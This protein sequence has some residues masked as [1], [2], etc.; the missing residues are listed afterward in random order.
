MKRIKTGELYRNLSA[1]L[2]RKG[3]EFKDGS[4]TER[5]KQSC[6]VLTDAVNVSQKA[7]ERAKTGV[8]TIRLPVWPGRISCSILI[9]LPVRT[10]NRKRS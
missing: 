4:Y 5:I 9:S 2:G 3:I 6:S 1:F 7:L 8:E 10:S